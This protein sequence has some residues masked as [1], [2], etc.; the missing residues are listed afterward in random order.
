M[1]PDFDPDP[2][3]FVTDLQEV[4]KKL[5]LKKSSFFKEKSQKEVTK[6][7]GSRFIFLLHDRR[8]RIHTSD[9]W[10]R[11]RIQEAQKH[12]DPDSDPQHWIQ[13]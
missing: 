12:T 1:D 10:I 4:N 5:T 11:I 7:E 9:Q 6:Q 13:R 8:I 3:V 2:A